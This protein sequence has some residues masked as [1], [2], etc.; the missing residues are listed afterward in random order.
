MGLFCAG[1]EKKGGCLMS[2]LQQYE[3]TVRIRFT[4]PVVSQ[5]AGAIGHGIDTA[6]LCGRDDIPVLPGTLLAGNLREIWEYFANLPDGSEKIIRQDLIDDWLGAKSRV[7]RTPR[8]GRLIFDE[9]WRAEEK[10]IGVLHH[11]IAIEQETG[12][13]KEGALQVIASPFAAGKEVAF[14]GGV[15]A[16]LHGEEEA[17][18]LQKWLTKGL[19]SISAM[20]ALKGAGF[21][22]VTGID[23]IQ[24]EE[25]SR[26]GK[27]A[28]TG[29]GVGPDTF[30]IGIILRPDR[31]FCFSRHGK[32]NNLKGDSASPE[33][34]RNDQSGPDNQ[35]I[36]E[37]YIPGG[38]IKGA[39]TTLL[40]GAGKK[41]DLSAPI[42]H[43]DYPLLSQYVD[44]LCI[45]RAQPSSDPAYRP[46]PLPLTTV[47][48]DDT[49]GKEQLYD[50][51]LMRGAGL[52]NGQAPAFSIDWKGG[53]WELAAEQCALP[54]QPSR[55]LSI[56]TAIDS[57]SGASKDHQ[58][59]SIEAV[60]PEGHCWSANITLP[61]KKDRKD[62]EKDDSPTEDERS[63]VFREL[64]ALLEEHGLHWLGKTGASADVEITEI[65]PP[66]VSTAESTA[67]YTVGA[68]LTVTLLSHAR[69]LKP[70][71]VSTATGAHDALFAAYAE[72]WFELS[73]DSLRLVDFYAAQELLGGEYW[74]E[75]Y[76]RPKPYNPE[77]FTA[78]G[79]VFIFEIA[80][81]K[82]AEEKLLD[83]RLCGLPQLKGVSEHWRKNPWIRENG[84]G[85]IAVNLKQ[86]MKLRPEP[87]QWISLE[88]LS[89][90]KR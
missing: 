33:Q 65:F 56:H 11:R 42:R 64:A 67:E 90:G 14:S 13:V 87:Q 59:F 31:P 82:K 68:V 51:A 60:N 88:E 86:H 55:S 69:L 80:D 15:T 63:D 23:E 22:R 8:R 62:D 53:T 49:E 85:E 46:L 77:I 26:T 50:I 16:W 18:Q 72:N 5:A 41:Y 10:G 52:I 54:A 73:G 24:Y 76:N 28:G 48:A 17:K 89:G 39:I 21:G 38:A 37:D 57:A 20:G 71:Q 44:Q 32:G 27:A 79:S 40:R 12:K 1:T 7:G 61:V 83:W 43:P 2:T 66:P 81:S 6:P 78:P 58:L 29:A 34:G 75:R 70:G 74:H 36:S 19:H 45:T 25:I 4:A 35:F 84:F 47:A 30:G 9:F 3:F